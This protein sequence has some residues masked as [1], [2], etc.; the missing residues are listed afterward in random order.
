MYVPEIGQFKIYDMFEV[1][2]SAIADPDTSQ[3]QLMEEV[4]DL[5]HNNA[6]DTTYVIH[7]STRVDAAD[8][9]QFLDTWSVRVSEDE[10]VITEENTP[11]VKF[12]GAAKVG[13]AWDGNAYNNLGADEYEVISLLHNYEA[14]NETFA[15]VVV[16]EQ[17]YNDDPIVYTDIRKEM[18][19]PGVGMIEKEVTQLEFCVESSCNNQNVIIGGIVLKQRLNN[20][21]V[22]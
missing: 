15:D 12:K 19:S 5:F 4:V 3:Y 13:I 8:E 10:L 22:N 7:R 18:Y 16:I 9:W 14:A 20:Y 1:T 6:G 17:E 11:Y 2:F 21:G